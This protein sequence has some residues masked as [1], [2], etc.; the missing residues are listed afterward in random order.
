MSARF[1]NAPSISGLSRS[2]K[3]AIGKVKDAFHKRHEELYTYAERH[4]AVEVVNIES[5]SFGRI[6]KPKPAKACAGRVASQSPEGTPQ[7]DFSCLRQGHANSQ[8]MTAGCSAPA[9][10]IAGP[11]IIEEVTTTIVIE[12][13]WAAT[14]RC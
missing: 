14:A 4:N 3:R 1:M 8:S 2:T 12:P 10:A 7:G 9:P 5:T 11:A 6:D 13:G